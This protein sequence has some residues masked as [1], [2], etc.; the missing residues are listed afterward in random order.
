MATTSR[1]AHTRTIKT[2]S[3]YGIGRTTKKVK[4]K[5]TKVRKK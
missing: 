5:A 2:P 1:K 3:K 4:V